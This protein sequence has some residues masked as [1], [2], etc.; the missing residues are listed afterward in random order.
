M[1]AKAFFNA[2]VID[3]DKRGRIMLSARQSVVER[4]DTIYEG[5]TAAFTNYDQQNQS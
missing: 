4:W 1:Q 5:S 3:T 2:R